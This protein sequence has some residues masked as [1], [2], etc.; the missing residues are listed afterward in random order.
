MEDENSSNGRAEAWPPMGRRAS[1][2]MHRPNA[3]PRIALPQAQSAA[4]HPQPS[5]TPS[6]SPS[7]SSKSSSSHAGYQLDPSYYSTSP[8]PRGP[9]TSAPLIRQRTAPADPGLAPGLP[10]GEGHTAFH[11]LPFILRNND[12]ATMPQPSPS[13]AST[14][15][16][17]EDAHQ[18]NRG[19]GRSDS[20]DTVRGPPL[21][22]T[23]HGEDDGSRATSESSNHPLTP[24]PEYVSRSSDDRSSVTGSPA[25]TVL[26]TSSTVRGGGWQKHQISVDETE[27]R[28]GGG[29]RTQLVLVLREEDGDTLGAFP[30]LRR[31]LNSMSSRMHGFVLGFECIIL[32][33]VGSALVWITVS[34][35]TAADVDFWAWYVTHFI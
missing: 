8:P 1:S 34:K 31:K 15:S 35:K 19:H 20:T 11:R 28:P 6:P 7:S 13:L 14:L 21:S 12:S 5:P 24:F 2:I 16:G 10:N 27:R 22:A 9:P 18:Q 33:L 4:R 32:L 17:Q 26:R 23:I 30:R 25:N 29:E 3:P